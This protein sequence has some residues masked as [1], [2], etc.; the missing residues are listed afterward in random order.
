MR[1]TTVSTGSCRGL[2]VETGGLAG[3]CLVVPGAGL[4]P[5][6]TGCLLASGVAGLAELDGELS[7]DR[8]MDVDARALS[9]IG[10]VTSTVTSTNAALKDKNFDQKIINSNLR[11]YLTK[12]LAMV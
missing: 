11:F 12:L 4:T 6:A 1:L 10:I 2:I 8:R 3:S 5:G 7:C 9:W